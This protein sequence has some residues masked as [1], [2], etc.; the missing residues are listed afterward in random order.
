MLSSGLPATATTSANFPAVTLPRSLS[1]FSSWEALTVAAWIFLTTPVASGTYATAISRQIGTGYDQHY[2][3]SVNDQQQA[4]LFITT[5]TAGQQVIGGPPSVPLQTWVH[6]AGTYDGSQMR[7][8]VNGV[9]VNSE[10]V[11]G[12]FATTGYW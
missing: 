12:P 3:L 11:S 4:I 9:E 8:Y 2:H 6:L 5:P 7:L 10:A 1:C